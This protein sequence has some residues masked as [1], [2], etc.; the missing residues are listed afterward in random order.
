MQ[1][2]SPEVLASSYIGLQISV[3]LLGAASM[4]C[5]FEVEL[6]NLPIFGVAMV[7]VLFCRAK[8]ICVVFYLSAVS[9]T[10]LAGE[11]QGEV[12]GGEWEH[13]VIE[14]EY[15]LNGGCD[16]YLSGLTLLERGVV[17]D[18]NKLFEVQDVIL[19]FYG[20]NTM[21]PKVYERLRDKGFD[22]DK[23]VSRGFLDLKGENYFIDKYKG[24]IYSKKELEVK[25]SVWLAIMENNS[26]EN[27]LGVRKHQLCLSAAIGVGKGVE[28][29]Y[30]YI[31]YA[32]ARRT[33]ASVGYFDIS[34]TGCSAAPK[35]GTGNRFSEPRL[36]DGSRFFIV[37]VKFKNTD[38]ESRLPVVGELYV[39]YGGKEYKFDS[40][41]PIILDG[42]NIWF[43]PINPL[44]AMETK[45]VYRIPDEL[46]GEVF[47]KPGRNS[48]GTRLWC[49]YVEAKQ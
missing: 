45:I 48:S 20:G 40:V 16:K 25:Y 44:I 19:S 47:W 29:V 9:F 7:R 26:D 24:G 22:I 43:R 5:E 37:N 41:E 42:Y 27:I 11:M 2:R 36:W 30:G 35:V 49:G 38:T 15:Y 28:D 32:M 39:N 17:K 13:E 3:A 46:E 12:D 31:D 33:R 10:A 6:R 14:D 8:L 1:A 34:V 23:K 18:I 21:S 4:S